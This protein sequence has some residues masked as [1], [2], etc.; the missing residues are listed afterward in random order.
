MSGSCVY[1]GLNNLPIKEPSGGEFN[2]IRKWI[3]FVLIFVLAASSLSCGLSVDLGT[4]KPTATVLP[5]TSLPRATVTTAPTPE[6]L[7]PTPTE[8]VVQEEAVPTEVPSP[9]PTPPPQVITAANSA[10]L[11]LKRAQGPGSLQKMK[12]SPD[13]NTVLFAFSTKLI[14]LNIKD[15]KPIW[16][17]DPGRLLWD[18]TFSKDG[19]HLV[20]AT[21]GGTVQIWDAASGSLLKTTIPQ[22]TGVH[23]VS[24]SDN[25]EYFAVLDFKNETTIWNTET[26]N[27]VQDNNGVANPGGINHIALSPGGG[28]LL[29]DGIDSKLNKQVQ[30]WKVTDGK[31]KIGLLGLVLDMSKWEFSPDANRIFGINHRSL[32]AKKTTTLTA[33]NANNGA[34]IKTFESVGIILRYLVSPDGSTILASTDD[35]VIHILNVET[36]KEKASFTG[37]TSEVAAMG[38]SPDS[39][40]AISVDVSGK[41]I[42]WDIANQKQIL[43]SES[44]SISPYS[45]VV[46]SKN[47]SMAGLL[48]PDLKKVGLLD[49][50]IWKPVQVVG[51]EQNALDH[52][53]ISPAGTYAAACDDQNQV[54]IWEV[55]SGKK[56]QKIEAKTRFPIYKMKFSP[57]EKLLSTLSDG[58]ILIFDISTGKKTK[59]FAGS[60]DFDY[61]PAEKTIVSD[62]IDFNLYFTDV[63]T[64]KQ[65]NKTT[66]EF[67]SSLSY[68]PDGRYIAIGGKK[69]QPVER[70][71]NNM[72]Y[73]IDSKS[74]ERLPVEISKIPGLVFDLA[75]NPNQD[76]LASKD[77]QGNVQIWDLK[78]GKL[79]ALFE[80][81]SMSP[82]G[83]TFN[84]DGSIL[85]VG[86]YDGTID[87]I[88]TSVSQAAEAP[89]AAD[90]GNVPVPELSG[91]PFTHTSGSMTVNLPKGWKI[92]EGS[93]ITFSAKEPNGLGSIS[94]L[95]INT[96]NPLT[97]EGFINYIN[98]TEQNLLSALSGMKETERKVEAQKGTAFITNEVNISNQVVILELYFTRKDAAVETLTFTTIKPVIEKYLPVYQGVFASFKMNKDYVLKQMPY[99]NGPTIQDPSGKFEYFTPIGWLKS[100][101]SQSTGPNVS[102]SAPD[103]S[104]AMNL[105]VISLKAGENPADEQIFV[106][107][108]TAMQ[109]QDSDFQV[110]KK[111]KTSSGNWQISYAIQSRKLNGIVIATHIGDTL[112]MLNVNYASDLAKQYYSLAVKVA[113]SL[114]KK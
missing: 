100:K 83:L 35:N 37:H 64:G 111:E 32:T 77:N 69:N 72:I 108:Q 98:G 50:S 102:Y 6:A 96:I 85:Y 97:D 30:Q 8:T 95:V 79:V 78:D 59:E 93:N 104:A 55:A 58:Q 2:M 43:A 87:I 90:L 31:Y 16:Q 49:T 57:D 112:Q 62:S 19:S 1:N 28:T 86:G 42:T 80:E 38:F 34:L 84:Q 91:Q 56:L 44:Q 17:V 21:F 27:Q 12:V 105:D 52:L 51:P 110:L 89:A 76:L 24:L 4:A 92:E 63:E 11:T 41:I 106:L 65:L 15:L 7:S 60:Y 61:S 73:L 47:G 14:L 101:T 40:G 20:S 107:M 29:I 25:G 13:G 74:L 113:A 114:K 82:G 10:S 48:S 103:G 45:P 88:S 67:I 23:D 75:F 99:Q 71:L 81:I 39:Q 33:W 68:S 5:P 18:V 54:I 53:A 26:G 22:K 9:T 94:A 46:F 36:G 66:A 3:F 109:K 70:G